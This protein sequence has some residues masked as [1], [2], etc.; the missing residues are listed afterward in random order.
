MHAKISQGLVAMAVGL[1]A[2]G[3]AGQGQAQNRTRET[4][5]ILIHGTPQ[6]PI[7]L[8][9][10]RVA[11]RGKPLLTLPA[12]TLRA[13]R[14]DEQTPT[15]SGFSAMNSLPE[16]QTLF[17]I[18]TPTG[19]AYCAMGESSR[20]F[21]VDQLVCFEDKDKDGR[22]E[23]VMA[24]GRP[25]LGVPFFVFQ[26]YRAQPLA[27]SVPYSRIDVLEGP[28]MSYALTTMRWT[29]RG[30]P[31]S[32]AI[33]AGYLPDPDKAMVPIRGMAYHREIVQGGV[34][35]LKLGGVEIDILNVDEDGSV[36]YRVM[37]LPPTSLQR[38]SMSITTT[39]TPIFIPG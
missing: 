19:W 1:V 20:R 3:V 14:L 10:E 16:G 27:V 12:T 11:A 33:Q 28:T 18:Y 24:A 25:F 29:R 34:T 21:L 7:V 4:A 38:S 5:P 15:V 30:Q 31:P 23:T 8:G 17:G 37:A 26:T 22:F 2:L 35:Q 39:S 6:E 36:R 32:I 9:E 13:V